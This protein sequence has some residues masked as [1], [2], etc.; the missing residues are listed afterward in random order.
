MASRRPLRHP[1]PQSRRLGVSMTNSTPA[2]RT[3]NHQLMVTSKP[4]HPT[5][6]THARRD[7]RRA[8]QPLPSAAKHFSLSPGE[9]AGVRVSRP[10]TAAQPHYPQ[11]ATSECLRRGYYAA[12]PP[13]SR[14]LT[15][16]KW[17]TGGTSQVTRNRH[18]GMTQKLGHELPHWDG[19]ALS[20]RDGGAP[21]RAG[22][23]LSNCKPRP[24]QSL[25]FAT[26]TASA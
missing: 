20:R 1:H 19:H 17:R 13:P 14:R 24:A 11:K 8:Q 22:A 9:R 21:L 18:R 15:T 23:R 7:N 2:P 25:P 26:L 6:Q 4:F 10:L 3:A 12:G 5:P 16:S